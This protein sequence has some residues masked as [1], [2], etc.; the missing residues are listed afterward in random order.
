MDLFVV[1]ITETN[2]LWLTLFYFPSPTCFPT[3]VSFHPGLR[4]ITLDTWSRTLLSYLSIFYSSSFRGFIFWNTF[5]SKVNTATYHSRSR[6]FYV[7]SSL[8]DFWKITRGFWRY[9]LRDW[10]SSHV[11]TVGWANV[12]VMIELH[13]CAVRK[14]NVSDCE[15]LFFLWNLIYFWH[16]NCL[17]LELLHI[18][19]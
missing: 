4:F 10:L 3:S 5:F 16:N 17:D 19:Y 7:F 15:S 18:H 8:S 2:V 11:Q 6:V 13:F 12:P 14:Q 1:V 9:W